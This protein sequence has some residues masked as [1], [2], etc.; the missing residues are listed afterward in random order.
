MP[1]CGASPPA[2]GFP[3]DPDA[4][5]P[6]DDSCAHGRLAGRRDAT[7]P[8]PRGGR[9]ITPAAHA[10]AGTAPGTHLTG[11]RLVSRAAGSRP[12]HPL[13]QSITQPA[14]HETTKCWAAA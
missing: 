11:A 3:R 10:G 6:A 5:M 1:R 2:D 14:R 7:A 12:G 4:G 9:A 13:T 8:A